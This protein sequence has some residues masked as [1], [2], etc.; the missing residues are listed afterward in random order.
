MNRA[1]EETLTGVTIEIL[2]EEEITL[3]R[4]EKVMVAE[5][6]LEEKAPIEANGTSSQDGHHLLLSRGNKEVGKAWS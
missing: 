6:S 4:A 2:T 1:V 5:G 3:T